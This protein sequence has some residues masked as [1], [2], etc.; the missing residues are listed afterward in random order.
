MKT[1]LLFVVAYF[2]IFNPAQSEELKVGI[3][4][5]EPFAY[6]E[7]GKWVGASVDLLDQL[8]ASEGFTY[9]LVEQS[10]MPNLLNSAE[11]GE[12][13]M[14]IAAISLT[15]QREKAVD[16]SHSYFS[17]SMGILAHSKASTLE[18]AWWVAKKILVIFLIFVGGLYA[19]GFIMDKVDGDDNIVGVNDGAWWALVT[20]TTTG[21]GDLVPKTKKGKLVAA[22]W[23]VASLFLISVFTGYVASSMTVK[24]LSETNTTL[25]D[26]YDE[27]VVVVKGTTAEFKLAE[28]G[29]EYNVVTSLDEAVTRFKSGKADAVVYDKAMLDY[30]TKDIDDV[31]VWPID[32][33]DEHYAIALPPESKLKERINLGILKTLSTSKWKAAKATYFGAE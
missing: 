20:F 33:S 21:Y 15:P 32:G 25:A 13:D 3:K 18:M 12:V 5:A 28:L 16:F 11:T 10:S 22:G 29:I 24:K 26:L 17:T 23:M 7:N 9:T 2:V 27:E 8:S 6:Q 31:D 4:V 30:A 14:A 1:F 19:I